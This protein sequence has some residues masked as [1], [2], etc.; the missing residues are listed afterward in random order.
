[1]FYQNA[2]KSFV[3]PHNR[4]VNQYHFFF[5][6]LVIDKIQIKPLW[7]IE[8]KLYGG[9]LPIPAQRIFGYKINFRPVKR[10]FANT[11]FKFGSSMFGNRSE[12]HT[13]ELQSQF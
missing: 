8:I 2:D 10:R 11:Y 12:E 7:L 13:S 4:A 1:M 6:P 3:R 9:H 5:L